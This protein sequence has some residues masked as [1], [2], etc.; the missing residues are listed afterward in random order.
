MRFTVRVLEARADAVVQS[1][2]LTKVIDAI[3]LA[4]LLRGRF[5]AGWYV[6]L[7]SEDGLMWSAP[8][9][10]APVPSETGEPAISEGA[11]SEPERRPPEP[12]SFAAEADLEDE[13][14]WVHLTRDDVKLYLAAETAYGELGGGAGGPRG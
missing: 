11:T 5:P 10:G 2:S 12:R 7:L 3:H 8:C 14:P 4:K 6:E 9:H 13:A 1:V